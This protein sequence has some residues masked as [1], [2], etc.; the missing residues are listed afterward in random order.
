MELN[1]L[2]F[3]GVRLC[4]A[5]ID[6]RSGDI[7]WT[8]ERLGGALGTDFVNVFFDGQC[9]FAHCRGELFRLDPMT[10]AVLWKNPLKG[11]GY[12]LAS[13]ASPN[14]PT[15]TVAAIMQQIQQQAAA[16]SSAASST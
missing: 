11:M 16:A 1:D 9:L 5:G 12:G 2:L 10:G 3:V 4:V 8:S 15:S 7:V 13:F 14:C 6:R